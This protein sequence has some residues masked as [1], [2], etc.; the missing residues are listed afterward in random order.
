MIPTKMNR[1]SEITIRNA[2]ITIIVVLLVSV[3]YAVSPQVC[4]YEGSFFWYMPCPNLS[5][6][7]PHLLHFVNILKNR[8]FSR[9]DAI[10]ISFSWTVLSIPFWF[11][12]CTPRQNY[13][14]CLELLCCN[15]NR[16]SRAFYTP[17]SLDSTRFHTGHISFP[18]SIFENRILLR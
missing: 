5:D 16:S 12:S 1:M 3:S 8:I 2:R 18:C 17:I 4:L 14:N 10:S 9:Q 15:L 6:S 7:V 13:E 11:C